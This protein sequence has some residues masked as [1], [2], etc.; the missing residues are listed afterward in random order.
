MFS[1][2]MISGE[3]LE[4]KIFVGKALTGLVWCTR[5]GRVAKKKIQYDVILKLQID[6]GEHRLQVTCV[7]S[8][9]HWERRKVMKACWD[10]LKERHTLFDFSRTPSRHFASRD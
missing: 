10:K 6:S 1:A 9:T 2:R 3:N 4:S 5:I 7:Q 8:I